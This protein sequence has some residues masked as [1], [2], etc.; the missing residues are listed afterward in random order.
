MKNLIKLL[1][2]TIL[3]VTSFACETT[4]VTPPLPTMTEDGNVRVTF[5]TKYS[6]ENID[7]ISTAR[8][9]STSDFEH[10]LYD[11]TVNVV[12]K[13][14]DDNVVID[15][16]LT[17][18]DLA[19]YQFEVPVGTYDITVTPPPSTID[20][21]YISGVALSQELNV[22]NSVVDLSL[23]TTQSAFVVDPYNTDNSSQVS[24]DYIKAFADDST[25]VMSSSNHISNGML[26]AYLDLE[27]VTIV[28]I[29][30]LLYDKGVSVD[31]G[32]DQIVQLEY[33]K[34]Y[35][36]NDVN[37]RDS[38]TPSSVNAMFTIGADDVMNGEYYVD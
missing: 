13:D 15:E 35:N 12:F 33:A 30:Y 18:V 26:Y 9:S 6:I 36:I 14:T 23:T 8:L 19:T 20:A 27:N 37:H 34:V 1:I 11:G 21:L 28:R 31:I 32:N 24:F 38:P 29:S 7:G 16:D 3:A 10:V 17:Y 4:T 5:N 2:V 25:P 22:D